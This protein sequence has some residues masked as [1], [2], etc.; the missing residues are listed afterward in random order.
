VYGGGWCSAGAAGAAAAIQEFKRK[1]RP[2]IGALFVIL[3]A[4]LKFEHF[5]AFG[6]KGLMLVLLVVFLCAPWRFSS[7]RCIRIRSEERIF[8]SYVAR[9]GSW[10]A[11]WPR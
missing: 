9:A 11:R 6:M 10:A 5:R 2:L 4:Q 7:A 8:L 1:S 3:S